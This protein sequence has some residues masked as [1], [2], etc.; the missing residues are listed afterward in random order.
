M[1]WDMIPHDL[2]KN[3][4]FL[5]NNELIKKAQR[6]FLIF[7]IWLIIVQFFT[8]RKSENGVS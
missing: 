1:D 8:K 3:Q 5:E 4:N 2:Y 6:A 7:N